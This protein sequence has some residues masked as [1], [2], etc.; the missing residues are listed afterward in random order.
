MSH[1]SPAYDLNSP[2]LPW[3]KSKDLQR[4]YDACEQ[5][6]EALRRGDTK[7]AAIGRVEVSAALDVFGING[8]NR[9]LADVGIDIVAHRVYS[10][11]HRGDNG[12]RRRS[13]DHERV[14]V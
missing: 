11:S 7:R 12:L 1:D 9:L 10:P 14:T 4:V 2:E 5:V 8:E 13:T 6:I 3:H